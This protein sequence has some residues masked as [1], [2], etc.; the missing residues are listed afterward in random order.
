M[1]NPTPE[2]AQEPSVPAD[3]TGEFSLSS[4]TA[5][6]DQ[7]TPRS[8]NLRLPRFLDWVLLV[9]L[10]LAAFFRLSGLYWGEYQYLHPDERFLVWVGSDI[11]P[12]RTETTLNPD[13][14]VGEKKIWIGWDEFFDTPNSTMN[15]NNRGHGFYVYGT[16]PMFIT[17]LAVEW[18]YGHSGFNEMTDIG[19]ALS[20]VADLLVIILIYAIGSRQY[21]RR[22]AALAA[23]FYAAM[24]LPIQQAHFFTMDTFIN[25]FTLLAL[26]FAVRI[27]SDQRSWALTRDHFENAPKP[28]SVRGIW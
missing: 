8:K 2:T 23:A 20:A 5:G 11:S 18:V 10:G 6:D 28:N 19:R 13:G 7:P 1:E 4:T 21:D 22:V 16:L 9:I 17:R 24:A 25:L 26:Y 15:P 12:A 27:S 14:S 3:Q